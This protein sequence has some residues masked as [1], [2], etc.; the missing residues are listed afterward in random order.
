MLFDGIKCEGLKYQHTD[1]CQRLE[2]FVHKLRRLS[3]R[4]GKA[5]PLDCD[6]DAT[7]RNE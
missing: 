2:R 5:I 4:L 3:I 1:H 7:T 6:V